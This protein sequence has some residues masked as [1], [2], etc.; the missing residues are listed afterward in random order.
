MLQKITL[1][2]LVLLLIAGAA[3]HIFNPKISDGF[4]PE[5]LPKKPVHIFTAIVEF[6]LGLALLFPQTRKIAALGI[7]GL[8]SFFL[9][10]HIQDLFREQPTIGS[11]TAAI[12]RIPFQFLFMY[13]AWL[14][15]NQD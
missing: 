12:I 4:I 7:I 2:V 8:L 1:Y 13:F 3:A 9:V 5:F 6:A 15:S 14:Q 11:K 10:L